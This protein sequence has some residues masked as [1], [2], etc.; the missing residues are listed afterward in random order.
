MGGFARCSRC[1]RAI[2]C[3]RTRSCQGTVFQS[4][5]DAF[6]DSIGGQCNADAEGIAYRFDFTNIEIDSSL[7]DGSDLFLVDPRDI[8]SARKLL[9]NIPPYTCR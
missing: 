8:R 9:P 3:E 5:A 2:R 7:Q 4:D 1:N 6:D